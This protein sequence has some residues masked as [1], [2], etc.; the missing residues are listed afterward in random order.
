MRSKREEAKEKILKI[1]DN[2]YPDDLTSTEIAKRS[3]IFRYTITK[4]LK[5]LTDEKKLRTRKIGKYAL[6]RRTR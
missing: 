3:K 2:S 4:Y 5:E 1:L 6:Y